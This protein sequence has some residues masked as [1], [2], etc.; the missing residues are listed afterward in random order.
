MTKIKSAR[1]VVDDA[2]DGL[3]KRGDLEAFLA[4]FDDDS[5]LIEASSLP[6]GGVFKGKDAIRRG[7][8]SIFEFWKDITFDIQQ[9]VDRSDHVMAYGTFRCVSTKTGRSIAMPI[10]EVWNVVDGRV[11][12]LRFFYEDTHQALQVLGLV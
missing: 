7:I 8:A 11:A 9:I 2:Y 3:F 10:V 4:D 1:E 6:Y 5:E 12:S